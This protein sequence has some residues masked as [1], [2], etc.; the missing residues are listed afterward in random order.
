M[1]KCLKDNGVSIGL[2]CLVA[3]MLLRDRQ[4]T[5]PVGPGVKSDPVV[6]EAARKA[7]ADYV[8]GV[9]Q[10]YAETGAAIESGKLATVTDAAKYNVDAEAKHL[11]DFKKSLAT[12]MQPRIGNEKLPVGSSQVFRDISAG[13]AKAV[14]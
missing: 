10:V 9:S 7:I 1:A 14:R 6:V 13:Y 3:F 2:F 5:V 12:I 11:E 8:K 4:N